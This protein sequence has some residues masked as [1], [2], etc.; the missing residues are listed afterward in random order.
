MAAVLAGL[1]G[2]KPARELRRGGAADRGVHAAHVGGWHRVLRRPGV[3]GGLRRQ[4]VRDR[5]GSQRRWSGGAPPA[6]GRALRV[7]RDRARPG[8][9]FR[10]RKSTRLNSSHRCIS[11]AVFCLKKKKK[12]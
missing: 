1:S 9:R 7:E 2:R 5:V 4:R 6:S 12:I 10:D 3:W 11:Y 8:Q